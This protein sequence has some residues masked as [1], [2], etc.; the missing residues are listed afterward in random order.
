MDRS[1][2]MSGIQK[3]CAALRHS[4]RHYFAPDFVLPIVVSGSTVVVIGSV[5]PKVVL[6]SSVIVTGSVE[7]GR[8]VQNTITYV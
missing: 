6:G 1:M 8:I 5:F 2:K 7:S 3:Y 4:L